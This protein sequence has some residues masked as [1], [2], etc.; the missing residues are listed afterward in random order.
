LKFEQKVKSEIP[1]YILKTTVMFD[2]LAAA[3]HITDSFRILTKAV[4]ENTF[5]SRLH[6]LYYVYPQ[7]LKDNNLYLQK[8]RELLPIFSNIK[9]RYKITLGA[10]YYIESIA[11]AIMK[12][13]IRLIK[14]EDEL[15]EDIDTINNNFSELSRDFLLT[16]IM[17]NALYK[18]ILLSKS[19]M[20]YYYNS[21]RDEEYK[22]IVWDLISQQNKY[23]AKSKRKKDNRLISLSDNNVYTIEEVIAQNKGKLILIDLWASW[24][25]PCL[26]QQPN[27]EK[28]HQQFAGEKISFLYI[29]MDK[30]ILKWKHKSTE[31]GL[32]PA[33]SYV[34]E[35]SNSQP[36]IKEHKI[37]TIPR[38]ILIDKSGKIITDDAP[39]PDKPE[40]KKLIEDHLQKI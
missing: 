21:C 25:V 36:F 11:D 7:V 17:Y 15:K 32:D 35:N 33:S 40:L 9:E 20:E 6:Y 39:T 24:C 34:F 14:T 8:Q 27:M 5:F 19:T 10:Y 37:E 31:I 30:E 13:H 1:G 23:A 38:Y 3:Y 26:E 2:S 22:T 29:S 16:K 28:L 18:S 4:F 12:T